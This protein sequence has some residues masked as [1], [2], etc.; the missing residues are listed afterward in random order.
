[1][2]IS[3]KLLRWVP[4]LFV[5]PALLALAILATDNIAARILLGFVAAGVGFALIGIK[6]RESTGESR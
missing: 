5:P 1:M 3:H 6:R 2:L 4:Y